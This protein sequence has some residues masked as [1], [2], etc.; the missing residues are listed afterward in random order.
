MNTCCLWL[1]RKPDVAPFEWT[2]ELSLPNPN[3]LFT[4]WLHSSRSHLKQQHSPFI[5]QTENITALNCR[6]SDKLKFC[7]QLFVHHQRMDADQQ[8]D[9]RQM[10]SFCALSTPI[11][12]Q[13]FTKCGRTFT[14]CFLSLVFLLVWWD[15]HWCLSLQTLLYQC[16]R[17]HKGAKERTFK[18]S[19]QNVTKGHLCISS[20]STA[21]QKL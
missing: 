16:D 1:W 8:G 3:L 18:K 21:E 14:K 5:I 10:S 4:E 11:H 17:Q 6:R 12:P 2:L 19:D 13:T 20:I 15:N 7:I 9:V